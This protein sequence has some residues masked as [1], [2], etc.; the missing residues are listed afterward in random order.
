MTKKFKRILVALLSLFSGLNSVNADNGVTESGASESRPVTGTYSIELGHRDVL[1]TYLSPLHYKGKALG[2]SGSWLKAMPFAPESAIMHFDTGFTFSSLLNPAHTATMIGLYGSFSWGMSW[3]CHL[4]N[5][6]QITAGG[7]IG[8]EGGAYYL[9]RNGNNPVE[10]I[11]NLNLALRASVSRPIK[12]GRL[13]ILLRD[14]ISVPTV[15]MFFSPEYGETYYEIYLGNHKGLI[16]A[17]WWGNNFR[18]DNLLTATLDFGRTAMTVG[19]RLDYNSQWAC[20]L[21]T[22]IMTHS[23]VIG[24]VPGGIGLKKKKTATPATTVYS[25]Y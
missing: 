22:R 12:I 4:P 7:A 21:N 11:A 14:E 15:G 23:F 20:S 10:A 17:G 3:R 19:Y 24:V 25:I 1:A 5:M 13:P 6:F 8:M 16:H 2:A 18:I 9:L